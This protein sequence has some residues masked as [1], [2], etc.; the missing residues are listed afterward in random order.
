MK[1]EKISNNENNKKISKNNKIISSILAIVMCCQ[2]L[3]G[4][5]VSDSQL[6]D[7]KKTVEITEDKNENK[8]ESK[9]GDAI[10]KSKWFSILVKT[11]AGI[12]VLGVCALVIYDEIKSNEDKLLKDEPGVTEPKTGPGE[13]KI[14]GLNY[15]THNI[16][17]ETE[18]GEGF[19]NLVI[20]ES[21]WGIH[22]FTN[23]VSKNVGSVNLRVSVN[24]NSESEI[25][26]LSNYSK[27]IVAAI[28]GGDFLSAY[29]REN[30]VS[31][32]V[33]N[34]TLYARKLLMEQKDGSKFRLINVC[35][36]IR[37]GRFG[38]QS[39]YFLISQELAPYLKV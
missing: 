24:F 37:L 1:K 32:D 34:I 2:P 23:E 16:G 31:S 10:D 19:E 7:N 30:K 17:E 27:F 12:S 20:G 6:V 5:F 33:D 35:V 9:K 29:L 15:F 14:G 28:K 39:A 3:V 13:V 25:Q 38:Y 21:D 4:A 8:D 22:D 11:I 18:N 36:R 26:N